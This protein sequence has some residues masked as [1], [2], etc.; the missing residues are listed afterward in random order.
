MQMNSRMQIRQKCLICTAVMMR[1][2][3]PPSSGFLDRVF[4]IQLKSKTRVCGF[5]VMSKILSLVLLP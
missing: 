2:R 4:L 5:F 3:E 1:G